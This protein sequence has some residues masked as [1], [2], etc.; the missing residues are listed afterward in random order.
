TAA[1][2][3]AAATTAAATARRVVT[4]AIEGGEFAGFIVACRAPGARGR[5]VR[6]VLGDVARG[7]ALVHHGAQ[8][9]DRC[10]CTQASAL[11]QGLD[12]GLVEVFAIA[13]AQG[14]RKFDRAVA[15][16]LQAAHEEALRIPQAAHFA[17]TAFADRD[18]E[19]AVAAAAADD[20][21]FVEAGGAVFQ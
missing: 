15:D 6:A 14:A 11:A 8:G 5:L 9:Q 19:P 1:T 16:A 10:R 3:L 13:A 12:G 2:R 4:Q 7:A 21:D 17:V 18:A 20:G